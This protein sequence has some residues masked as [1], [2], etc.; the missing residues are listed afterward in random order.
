[1]LSACSGSPPSSWTCSNIRTNEVDNDLCFFSDSKH[2]D[3]FLLYLFPE[4]C[5]AIF[6]NNSNISIHTM[7]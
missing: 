5:T 3:G 2:F 4:M 7:R 1:M 6:V